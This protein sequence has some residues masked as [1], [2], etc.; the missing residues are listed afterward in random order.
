MDIAAEG[1]CS[2]NATARQCSGR[3]IARYQ[4]PATFSENPTLVEGPSRVPAG[5]RRAGSTLLQRGGVLERTLQEVKRQHQIAATV[6]WASSWAMV[7]DACKEKELELVEFRWFQW[8]TDGDAETLP[9]VIP[10]WT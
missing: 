3:Q 8:E 1:S 4:L 9:D 6:G 10:F 2:L 7:Q 5:E